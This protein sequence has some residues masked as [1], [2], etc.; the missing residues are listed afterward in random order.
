M[1]FREEADEYVD[2]GALNGIFVLGRSMGFIG[3][4]PVVL[5][6]S[7]YSSYPVC[8]SSY[9]RCQSLHLQ[10]FVFNCCLGG[11]TWRST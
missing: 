1:C 6:V 8:V 4:L 2:I 7:G 9:N 3:E 10:S 5:R 11:G